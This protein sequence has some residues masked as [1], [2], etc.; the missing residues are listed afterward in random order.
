MRFLGA[1][2]KKPTHT[3]ACVDCG[4]TLEFVPED[5]L[6][7]SGNANNNNNVAILQPI[8]RMIAETQRQMV[9]GEG[10]GRRKLTGPGVALVIVSQLEGRA[11]ETVDILGIKASEGLQMVWQVQDH[12]ELAHEPQLTPIGTWQDTGSACTT[13]LRTS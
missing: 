11:K 6:D 9:E 4:V 13:G 1:R 7:E 3:L 5:D 12:G 10:N 8:L 2:Q